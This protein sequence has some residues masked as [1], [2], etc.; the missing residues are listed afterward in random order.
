MCQRLTSRLMD[1][2]QLQMETAEGGRM[3]SLVATAEEGEM[4]KGVVENSPTIS[5]HQGSREP[6]ST[7]VEHNREDKNEEHIEKRMCVKEQATGRL[8]MTVEHKPGD[9]EPEKTEN[10]G[11]SVL[12]RMQRPQGSSDSPD[13]TVDKEAARDDP[14][15]DT[16][17][18]HLSGQQPEETPEDVKQVCLSHH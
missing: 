4:K 12:R 9:D 6:T 11:Q 15:I 18:L 16:K 7:E 10:N 1:C 5:T 13:D 2:A 14:Q 8:D 3:D 17:M